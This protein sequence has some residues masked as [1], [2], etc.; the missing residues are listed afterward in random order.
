LE[1]R[2]LLVRVPWGSLAWQRPTAV[3]IAQP[4]RVQRR[5]LV[6]VTRLLLLSMVGAVLLLTALVRQ[7]RPDRRFLG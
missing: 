4:G 3:L 5:R 2:T 7:P 6:D 1:A